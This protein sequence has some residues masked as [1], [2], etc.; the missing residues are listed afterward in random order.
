MFTSVYVYIYVLNYGCGSIS[1]TF[2]VLL[3]GCI[4]MHVNCKLEYI[5]LIFMYMLIYQ[6]MVVGILILRRCSINRC[7]VWLLKFLPREGS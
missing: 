2:G 7:V 3:S 5:R 6:M 4:N 1:S